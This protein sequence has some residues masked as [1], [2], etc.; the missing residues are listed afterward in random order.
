MKNTIKR[1]VPKPFV[2]YVKKQ[3]SRVQTLAIKHTATEK[4][5]T[6]IY[7]HNSWGGKSGEYYSGPGTNDPAIAEPYIACLRHLS[8][9]LRFGAMRAVDLG[10]GDLFIGKRI[11]QFFASYVGVDIVKNLI[12]H[13]QK[14]STTDRVTF[15]HLNIIEDELPSGDVCLIRQVLQHLSNEQ[16]LKI[17]PK[18]SRYNYVF[19][20]EHLPKPDPSVVENL[21]MLHGEHIRLG[22]NSGVFLTS[23]PFCLQEDLFETV[24]EIEAYGGIIRTMLYRPSMNKS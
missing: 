12:A 5:F 10:C 11:S 21:D 20:T 24:L 23:P 17:L 4:I 18:F 15:Q 3:T 7:Q 14:N 22:R 8:Q 19:I 1:I 2:A 13:H 9:E 6:R 16:I